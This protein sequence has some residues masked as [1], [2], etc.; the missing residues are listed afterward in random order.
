MKLKKEKVYDEVGNGRSIYDEV[1]K[2]KSIWGSWEWE[3]YMMKL[4]KRKVYDEVEMGKIYDEVGKEKV[5]QFRTFYINLLNHNKRN[6]VLGIKINPKL[7]L[8]RLGCNFSN[9]IFPR[10]KT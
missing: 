2:G 3:K 4:E 7:T 10:T 1:G 6:V 5:S 9:C 8:V